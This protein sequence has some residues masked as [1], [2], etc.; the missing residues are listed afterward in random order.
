MDWTYIRLY[1]NAV[2]GAEDG[3]RTRLGRIDNPLPSQRTTS[4][5]KSGLSHRLIQ[6]SLLSVLTC[7]PCGLTFKV[8]LMRPALRSGVTLNSVRKELKEPLCI[9]LYLEERLQ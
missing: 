5:I 7:I 6:S 2:C 4:A 8:H 3:D 9:C 1:L